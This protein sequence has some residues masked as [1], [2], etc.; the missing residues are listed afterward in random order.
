MLVI[1]DSYNAQPPS[2][3]AAIATATEL[4][5]HSKA[6]LIIILG[7]MLELGALSASSHDETIE[8]VLASRP[9]LF[10]AVGPEM[11]A[12]LT[13]VLDRPVRAG[14]E[15]LQ[16]RDSDEATRLIVGKLRDGDVVL[17]KGSLGMAM[18]RVVACLR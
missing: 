6:R 17:V 5:E 8:A 7:D 15:C 1:D 2:M 10:V 9:A 16:A 11:T 18:D 3:R 13:R 14:V 4:A 12:A